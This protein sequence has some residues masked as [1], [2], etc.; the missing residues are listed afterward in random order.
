MGTEDN[1]DKTKVGPD[2][3]KIIGEEILEET[4]GTMVDTIVEESIETIIERKVMTE[5]GIGLEKG[6]FWEIM[7][8]IKIGVQA[9]VSPDQDPEQEQ[10]ET[11]FDVVSVG[12]M[13][14]LQ[15]TVPLLEKKM[16]YS[17]SNKCSIWEMNKL[18]N[19]LNIK[20]TS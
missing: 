18:L 3:N 4:W 13:I 9:I 17:S 16:K 1:T 19:T 8:T 10:I 14:I 5:A 12:N 15:R 20:H 7:A 11:E 6:H 2:I